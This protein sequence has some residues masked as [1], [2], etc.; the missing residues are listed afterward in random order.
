M[1]SFLT[2]APQTPSRR[3]YHISELPDA[4]IQAMKKATMNPEYNY[5]NEL[6]EPLTPPDKSDATSTSLR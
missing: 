5:L 1:T 3:A 6:K 4:T 2:H